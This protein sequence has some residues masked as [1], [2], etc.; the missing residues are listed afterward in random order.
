MPSEFLGKTGGRG[1]GRRH[2]IG[3]L[4]KSEMSRGRVSAILDAH[5]RRFPIPNACCP[6]GGSP[7]VNFTLCF[8]M[9]MKTLK[10]TSA[11]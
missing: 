7:S 3:G 5:G 8:V 9:V 2:V 6:M 10:K 1:F 4:L 11:L